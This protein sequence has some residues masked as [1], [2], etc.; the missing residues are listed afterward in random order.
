ML[1]TCRHFD[2][3]RQLQT[4][5]LRPLQPVVAVRASEAAAGAPDSNPGESSP[6]APPQ[7]V[8]DQVPQST[9]GSQVL[10]RLKE[11][12]PFKVLGIPPDS[13]FEEVMQARNF[14]VQVEPLP[15]ISA[16]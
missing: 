4:P 11:R 12:D 9:G 8:P 1:S 2:R 6:G 7:V 16:C 10:P 5:E 14:L 3:C 13:D 15:A